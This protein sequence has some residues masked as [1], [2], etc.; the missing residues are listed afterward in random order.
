MSEL[1]ERILIVEIR[2][3]QAVR[4]E[5]ALQSFGYRLYRTEELAK[6]LELLSR[7]KISLI[8]VTAVAGRKA[9]G[10]VP[11]GDVAAATALQ[12]TEGRTS[13]VAD[14]YELCRQLESHPNTRQAPLLLVVSDCDPAALRS[15]LEA[16]ADYLL[17]TPYRRTDLLRCIRNALLNGVSPEPPFVFP[18]VEVIHQ[19][20][21]CTI[22]A[23]RGRLAQLLFALYDDL[24]HCRAALSWAQA[25]VRELR[26]QL[27]P[28]QRPDRA[29][30]AWPQIVQG[31]TH[32]LNNL[33]ETIRTAS[34]GS[35]AAPAFPDGY[36]TAF[37]AALAQAETL[38]GALQDFADQKDEDWPAE[39]VE[40]SA[41]IAQVLEAALLPLRAP[42]VRVEVRASHLPPIL[43][44]R[45]LV[46]RCLH[47][48][49]WNAVQAMPSGG[50]VS[51]LGRV[52]RNQ[53]LLEVRDT[54]VGILK[55][56]Q[57]KIFLPRFTTK[58]EHRGLG[59]PLV[60]D[61]VQRAGGGITVASRP[62]QGSRFVLHFPIADLQ[63]PQEHREK[64]AKHGVSTQ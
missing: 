44:N 56:D 43:S 46:S 20:R 11:A 19:D 28:G 38:V 62:R 58:G 4:L 52:E 57:D 13:A 36:Q 30:T 51:V 1:G 9:L 6:A 64:R 2:R 23:G 48:L 5:R 27:H 55:Q 3:G 22:T 60:R 54:G 49:I 59:L 24:L 33:L 39:I 8:L 31:I 42:K 17:L 50:T 35:K 37:E 53:V 63:Q 15:V 29:D 34:V 25:E 61:L 12:K 18:A 41:V 45:I 10:S 32:D 47:N 21:M 26:R 40:P 16:G 7:E 14:G